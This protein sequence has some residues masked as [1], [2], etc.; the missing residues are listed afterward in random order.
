M[1]LKLIGVVLFWR[2]NNAPSIVFKSLTWGAL[3]WLAVGIFTSFNTAVIGGIAA[4]GLAAVKYTLKNLKRRKK[5]LEKVGG[6]K[7]K[8]KQLQAAT[9]KKGFAGALINEMLHAEIDDDDDED[10]TPISDEE[11]EIL[12]AKLKTR[13][14]ELSAALVAGKHFS[15]E[16]C[17][18]VTREALEDY[19]DYDYEPSSADILRIFM[20]DNVLGFYTEDFCNED[21]HAY[22]VSMFA[23]STGGKWDAGETSSTYDEENEK[24]LVNFYDNGEKKTWR[25]TQRGDELNAKFLDQLIHYTERKSGNV[26]EVLEDCD[27]QVEISSLPADIHQLMFERSEQK[28]A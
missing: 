19:S 25:F 9:N 5:L 8:L 22:L 7:E 14:D 2:R 11:K 15:K 13:C 18:E 4:A 26:L 17:D 3:A 20:P 24:W 6:D 12:Q 27:E 21:D 28:A 16:H 10:Y 23:D 1:L